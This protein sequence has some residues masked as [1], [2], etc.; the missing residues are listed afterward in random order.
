MVVKRCEWGDREVRF[1][2][3]VRVWG[4]WGRGFESGRRS[5]SGWR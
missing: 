5:V 2:L 4:R 1:E 3:R